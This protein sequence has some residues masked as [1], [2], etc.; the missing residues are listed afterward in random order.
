MKRFFRSGFSLIL[1]LNLLSMSTSS[2]AMKKKK[3]IFNIS[4]VSTEKAPNEAGCFF[5]SNEGLDK[6]PS[7]LPRAGIKDLLN[8]IYISVYPVGLVLYTWGGGWN[9]NDNEAGNSSKTL[10][11]KHRLLSFT[12]K[13]F[14]NNKQNTEATEQDDKGDY[15]QIPAVDELGAPITL[16]NDNKKMLKY[17][18]D[19][20][21]CSGFVGWAVYN[22]L[23]KI[24]GNKGYVCKSTDLAKLLYDEEFGQIFYNVQREHLTKY[25]RIFVIHTGDIV[26]IKGHVYISLG[27]CKDGS[28]L[29]VHSSY[30]GVCIMGTDSPN[31]I[32]SE[33][34]AIRLARKCNSLYPKWNAW[35][36]K[37]CN[38]GFSR[39]ISKYV[40]DAQ[41][42][43]WKISNDN[44]IKNINDMSNKI[45]IT[46]VNGAQMMS[47]EEVVKLI[48]G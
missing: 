40:H 6:R 15:V 36:N 47:A 2:L 45:K 20:F 44:S 28:I 17:I 34:D 24:S 21:D 31:N 27:Q 37:Y 7:V 5:E 39:P 3:L 26:S 9:P 19:G 8:F 30:P 18:Y 35:Y 14:D 12:R 48:Y 4:K 16:S 38:D 22:F 41:V 29:L 23:N 33:S 42:F 32:N 43:S 25:N 10:G 46:D 13:H 1:S 11:L